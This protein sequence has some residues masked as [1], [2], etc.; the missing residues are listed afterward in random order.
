MIEFRLPDI[1]EGIAEA[2][3]IEWLVSEGDSVK[4]DQMIVKVET[5]KAVADLPSP[6]AGTIIKINFKKGEVVNVGSV[7]CVIGNAGEKISSAVEKRVIKRN[8]IPIIKETISA[9]PGKVIA[10]P[11]VRKSASERGI[12]LSSIKGTGENGLILISDL[13]NRHSDREGRGKVEKE[14]IRPS[15]IVAQKKYDMFGYVDRVPFKGIRKTIAQNMIK[16]LNQTAQVTS[17]EDIEVTK[18][19]EIRKREKEHFEIEGVKLTFMPFIIKAVISALQAHPIL[20]SS[21][22]DEEIIVKKYYNI[23]VAVQTEAGLMVP[24]VKI[25]EKKSIVDI[26]REIVDLAEKC[27]NR[28]I[29]IMDIK[30]STFTITNYGSVGG[31]YG[32]PIINPGESA[33]LG[34]GRIFDRVVLDSVTNKPKNVKILPV[35]LT[36]DH[37]IIDGAVASEFLVTLK[38]LLEEP[39]SLFR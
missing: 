15:G 2:T 23:G 14:E 34:T 16:S 32:T 37:Q 31:T 28:T 6:V 29:D 10:S 30:G 36:F 7:L 12:D 13:D 3:I 20:N 33:I 9:V 8:D 11:A 17:M 27:R 19:W 1:G 26:A 4:N 5:D 38:G 18:L 24:V 25:A 39:E 22:E 21:L 35:S